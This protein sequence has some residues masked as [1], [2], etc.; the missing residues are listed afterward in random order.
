MYESVCI[1]DRLF[2]F[3]IRI[4]SKFQRLLQDVRLKALSLV[5]KNSPFYQT[6]CF[7]NK[8]FCCGRMSSEWGII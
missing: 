2:G 5:L 4:V 8:K 3:F 6:E 1:F 7:S